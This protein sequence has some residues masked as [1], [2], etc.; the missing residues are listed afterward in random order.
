MLVEDYGSERCQGQKRDT[1]CPEKEVYSWWVK[2][3]GKKK[4]LGQG[5]HTN[6]LWPR[7]PS[8][9]G[10]QTALI[11]LTATPEAFWAGTHSIRWP[12]WPQH[13]HHSLTQWNLEIPPRCSVSSGTTLPP[14]TFTSFITFILMPSSQWAVRADP[15]VSGQESYFHTSVCGMWR[16]TSDCP[17]RKGSSSLVPVKTQIQL[18]LEL[19]LFL[20][21]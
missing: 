2:G 12:L 13:W 21:F 19:L 18:H 14:P 16:L 8:Y 15:S 4:G 1:G 5:I 10:L 7:P 11:L 20:A 17:I 9:T 6:Q 3:K